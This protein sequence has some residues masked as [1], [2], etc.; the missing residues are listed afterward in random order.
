MGKRSREELLSSAE[1]I[2]SSR[3]DDTYCDGP[4]QTD[5]A[6]EQRHTSKYAQVES[7][8]SRGIQLEVMWC[9]LPPHQAVSFSSFAEYEVHY[10]KHHVSR[11]SACQRNFPSDHYLGLHI[12]E[13]HDPLNE[14]RRE[15]GERTVSV[16]GPSVKSE[17]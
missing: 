17:A 9:N 10:Q 12:A 4:L 5:S 16:L 11:C 2:G 1:G 8:A 7:S 15:K 14:A 6:E 3:T 13:N